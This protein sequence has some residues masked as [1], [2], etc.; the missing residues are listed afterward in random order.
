M[1][2]VAMVKRSRVDFHKDPSTRWEQG[3][4]ME[5][6]SRKVDGLQVPQWMALWKAAVVKVKCRK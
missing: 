2:E 6:T 4:L 5:G 1:E 3:G